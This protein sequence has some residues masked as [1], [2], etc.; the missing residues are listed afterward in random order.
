MKKQLLNY[1]FLLN[2]KIIFWIIL[3]LVFFLFN[4]RFNFG[5]FPGND[6]L[7]YKNIG[8]EF[9]FWDY[10]NSRYMN[11]SARLF[12]DAV[13]YYIFHFNVNIWKI[14][15]TMFLLLLC[16]SM[17]RFFKYQVLIYD[18][19]VIISLLWY[20]SF[21]IFETAF[22]WATGSINYLWPISMGLFVLIPYSDY[23]FRNKKIKLNN[24][25]ILVNILRIIITLCL[26]ISN[27]QISIFIIIIMIYFHLFIYNKYKQFSIYLI[28]ITV[29][30]IIGI[31]FMLF[32]PGNAVR[33]KSE[34]IKWYPGFD[35]IPLSSRIKIGVIW[36]CEVV[37]VNLKFIFIILSILTFNLMKDSF[38]KKLFLIFILT[39]VSLL[40]L[41]N[42]ILFEF[43]TINNISFKN[44]NFN[45]LSG[46]FLFT[47]F[48][49]VLWFSFL[50]MLITC[51]Y[52]VSKKN[53]F[54]L[55]LYLAG[56]LTCIMMTF[57]PTL[58]ASGTRVLCCFLVSLVSIGFY[59]FQEI[60]NKYSTNRNYYLILLG[61]FS[62]FSFYDALF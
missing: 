8:N 1:N 18:M 4:R 33:Y 56:I 34:I 52:L 31:L 59:L 28:L 48:P 16:Y 42:P 15:N 54:I 2:K 30:M 44:P 57:S 3:F 43:E 9:L 61:I 62:I 49:F 29:I 55:T 36:F 19:T 5:F 40:L 17:I 7:A 10:L 38:L 53:K 47:I 32:A 12:P 11:W 20:S 6:D 50:G 26:S 27:E 24:S 13:T 51:S 23:Y 58:Y 21:S 14:F 41:K 37:I 22:F 45:I 60:I 46:R 25:N 35:K 39:V